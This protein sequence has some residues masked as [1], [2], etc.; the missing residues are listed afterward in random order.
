[1]NPSVL[2][3][4]ANRGIG[5]ALTRELLANGC[6]VIAASRSPQNSEP[7]K[8]L[9]LLHHSAITLVQLDVNDAE[10]AASVAKFVGEQVNGLDLLIN[11]AAIFPEEGDE[12]IM[13]IDLQHFRDAF[14][15]NV[16]G[17]IRMT[18]AFLPLLKKGNNPRVVNISSGAGSISAKEDSGYYAYA[19]SKAALNMV[20]R[21]M[22]AEF[23]PL[24]ISVVA[25]TPG[26]VKTKMGGENAP[27]TP[28]QSARSIA[29]T[30]LSLTMQATG[31]F[32]ERTGTPSKYAW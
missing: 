24:E 27:L 12:S 7:L 28:E 21:A 14:E 15:T 26:W 6:H 23:K 11:N 29:R 31:Q 10:A 13:D 16:L 9:E 8:E 25:L 3:T 18:R 1:M 17:V 19:A 30:A 4:G 2:I 32:L 5:L 22:A 20:T